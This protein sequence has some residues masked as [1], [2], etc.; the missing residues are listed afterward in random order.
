MREVLC[1]VNVF[2]GNMYW[3]DAGRCRHTVDVMC[4]HTVDVMC[5]HTV[6]VMCRHTVDVMCRHTVDVMCRHT[7]DSLPEGCDRVSLL[8]VASFLQTCFSSL[9]PRTYCLSR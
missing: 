8:I 9:M 4:R 7:I 1:W 5:R 3:G 2:D 6:D